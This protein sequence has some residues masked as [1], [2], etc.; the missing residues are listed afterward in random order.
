MD[1]TSY[2]TACNCLVARQAARFITQF[3]ER[4]FSQAAV[5]GPQFSILVFL[6]QSPDMTMA[7]L[8]RAMV[9]DRTT[10]VRGLQPMLRDGLLTSAP[11]TPGSRRL[12]I[13]LTDKGL[14][15]LKETLPC[16]KAAQA[17]FENFF[18]QD[19]AE[20]LRKELLAMATTGG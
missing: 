10:L 4:H 9:I 15:T 12:V 5:T 17:E 14:V 11:K 7:E 2:N 1:P 19:R 20:N 8:A 18:G 3:Y 16:W 13:N 6:Q